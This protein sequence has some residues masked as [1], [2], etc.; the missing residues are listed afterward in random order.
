MEEDYGYFC[1]IEDHSTFT[2]YYT[3]RNMGIPRI[4]FQKRPN[5]EQQPINIKRNNNNRKI[6]IYTDAQFNE[7]SIENNRSYNSISDSDSEDDLDSDNNSNSK[8]KLFITG[9]ICS[10][11][12]IVTIEYWLFGY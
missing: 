4:Y 3:S 2:K 8:T 5:N 12:V 6:I 7:P 10:L 11:A 9:V 1:E